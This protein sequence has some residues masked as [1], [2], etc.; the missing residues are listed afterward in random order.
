VL[1]DRSGPSS[2]GSHPSRPQNLRLAIAPTPAEWYNPHAR[3]VH[4]YR[5]ASQSAKSSTRYDDPLEQV[6][7][8][9]SPVVWRHEERAWFGAEAT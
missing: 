4:G 1:A 7:A 5:P 2:I 9:K 8:P 3:R 6:D